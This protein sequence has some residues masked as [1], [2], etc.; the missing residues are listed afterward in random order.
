MKV[1]KGMDQQ[2]LVKLCTHAFGSDFTS[3]NTDS[4][5]SRLM[6][7]VS[8]LATSSI[9]SVLISIVISDHDMEQRVILVKMHR[10]RD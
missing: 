10:L 6:A 4:M 9:V 7:W 1:L 2:Q 5:I 8:S 3:T